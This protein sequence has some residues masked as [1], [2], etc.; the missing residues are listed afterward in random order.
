MEILE[1]YDGA[2]VIYDIKLIH[3]EKSDYQEILI[4]THADFGTCLFLDGGINSSSYDEF[5]YH[6]CLVHPAI[7]RSQARRIGDVLVIGG[8]S[9]Q[10]KSQS[11]VLLGQARKLGGWF[12]DL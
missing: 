5:I 9:F 6:E 7:V 12:S 4:G 10:M 1:R 2:H 8:G 3:S 11:L